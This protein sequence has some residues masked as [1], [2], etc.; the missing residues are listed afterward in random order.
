MIL[1][2]EK[3]FFVVTVWLLVAS[4]IVLVSPPAV[5]EYV[6]ENT[7]F[8]KVISI[9]ACLPQSAKSPIYLQTWFDSYSKKKTVAKIKFSKLI[10]D[11]SCEN[12]APSFGNYLLVY[13]WKVNVRGEHFLS[14]YVPNLNESFDG[15]PDGVKSK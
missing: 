14:F 7:S 10:F 5:A 4:H 1:I 15:W 9:G 12:T 2:R 13:K 3:R 8:G 11:K 6:P